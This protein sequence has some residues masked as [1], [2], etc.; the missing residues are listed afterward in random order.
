MDGVRIGDLC[1]CDDVGNLQVAFATGGGPDT[2]RFVRKTNVQAFFVG[3][4]IDRY[5]LNAHFF[6]GSDDPQGNLPTIGY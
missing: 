2:N 6:T 4:R 5:G 1:G 3:L